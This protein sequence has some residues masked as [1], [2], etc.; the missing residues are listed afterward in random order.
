[1][2]GF[3]LVSAH[4]LARGHGHIRELLVE[5]APYLLLSE[6]VKVSA[7]TN[8]PSQVPLP[9]RRATACRHTFTGCRHPHATTLAAAATAAAVAAQ[10]QLLQL[11]LP[12]PLP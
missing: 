4:L 6:S 2:A 8:V 5:H 1:M 12:L 3:W 9:L 7:L 10:Q 11:L